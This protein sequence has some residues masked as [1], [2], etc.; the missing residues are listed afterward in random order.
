MTPA[1]RQYGAPLLV[2]LTLALVPLVGSEFFVT[3]VLTRT[4]MLGM[5]AA[6]IVFLSG[7]GGM[8]SMAQLLMFG[9]SGFMIGNFSVSEAGSK[10]LKLGIDP[11]LSVVLAL[12]IT[13]AVA[14]LLGAISSR[15]TG[16]YYLM[17]TFIFAVIG[18]LFFGQVTTFSGFGGI[19]GI[20]PP[21][22][23]VDHPIRLYLLALAL[24]ALTYVALKAVIRPPFGLALQGIRDEPVRM[25][26]LGWNVA[27]HRTLAFTMAGFIAGVSGVLNVWWNGQ[28]DPRSISIG[29]TIDLLI[30]AVIG[31]MARLEGAWLGAFVFVAANNY[32]RS[33]PLIDRI[34][35][36]E[37]RFN[38]VIGLLV[39]LIVIVSPDGITGLFDRW[40]RRFGSQKSRVNARELAVGGSTRYTSISGGDEP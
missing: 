8:T 10:G 38:T 34:G 21:S 37:A 40:R 2:L 28:I 20:D 15:T 19:T 4:L 39:L 17:L 18:F 3:F 32:L 11:W 23:F 7:F 35:I 25:A 30:I 24:S 5:A 36:T 26:A 22:V 14:L 6:T 29:P 9:I 13:T 27:L 12:L 31:G 1:V 16:I 33:I